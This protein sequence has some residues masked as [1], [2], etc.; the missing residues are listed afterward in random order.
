M[1]RSKS[2][3]SFFPEAY[4]VGA[5]RGWA[6][7]TP[8]GDM[9]SSLYAEVAKLAD[10]LDSGSSARKGVRVQIPPSAPHHFPLHFKGV[11]RFE[12]PVG[13]PL[14]GSDLVKLSCFCH[15]ANPF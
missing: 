7:R 14:P 9:F 5:L 13:D 6:L 10:A 8:L 4:T 12:P 11:E 3:R 15:V 1:D 2:A